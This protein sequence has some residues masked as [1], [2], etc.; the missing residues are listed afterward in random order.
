MMFS[1]YSAPGV[2]CNRTALL[3]FVAVMLAAAGCSGPKAVETARTTDPP[4]LLGWVPQDSV[5]DAGGGAYRRVY[6]TVQ[7]QAPFIELLRLV[8]Q[9]A[10]MLV[11]F[12]SWC[13]D[14]RRGVPAFVKV[15][16]S[17]GIPRE[18]VS[19]YGVDRS[20]QAADPAVAALGIE[21]V[22]TMVVRRGGKEIGRIVETP[23]VSWEADLLTIL[24]SGQK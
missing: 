20:K 4:L 3:L 17:A 11:V 10:D 24:G 23:R 14:S 7:V 21:A 9:D 18:R 1:K 5:L 8:S 19:F 2:E 13:G 22:P 16:E 15:A 12:G 6:D